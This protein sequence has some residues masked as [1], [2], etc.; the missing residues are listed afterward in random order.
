MLTQEQ[1]DKAKLK[2]LEQELLDIEKAVALANHEQ[3]QSSFYDYGLPYRV[4]LDYL[5]QPRNDNNVPINHCY[6][7]PGFELSKR[8][9]VTTNDFDLS[10]MDSDIP[11]CFNEVFCVE[12]LKADKKAEVLRFIED[13]RTWKQTGDTE[14]QRIFAHFLN[15]Y[16]F[17]KFTE[18]DFLGT[19]N[20]L[21]QS[22]LGL[23]QKVYERYQE[24]YLQNPNDYIQSEP[25]LADYVGQFGSSPYIIH[26][27]DEEK[28]ESEELEKQ[29]LVKSKMI[30]GLDYT[31]VIEIERGLNGNVSK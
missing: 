7:L 27:T 1:R 11:L 31:E 24:D 13:S 17:S 29:I 30:E 5:K 18:F 9:N 2:L 25:L 12:N 6:P 22:D 14:W 10:K 28:R 23:L 26:F 19:T 20:T 8:V 15:G 16:D 3:A 4:F 21:T